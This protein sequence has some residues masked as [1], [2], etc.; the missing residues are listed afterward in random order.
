MKGEF[1]RGPR[2]E[3]IVVRDPDGPTRTEVFVDGVAVPAT[4]FTV[5]AGRGWEWSDWTAMRDC[6]LAVVS[7]GAHSALQAAYDDP[8]GGE[9]VQDRI[10][11]W[12][13]GI[14]SPE[15]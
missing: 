6:D 3:V 1:D 15:S 10:G 7:A 9:Y 12:L 8:P 5:G 11:G 13:V 14:E 2:I 4:E